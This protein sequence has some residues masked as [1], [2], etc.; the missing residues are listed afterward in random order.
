[1]ARTI[2]ETMARG[3]ARR[4]V[5]R[6]QRRVWWMSNKDRLNILRRKTFNIDFVVA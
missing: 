4:L 2:A 5:R 6:E 1:M 3:L